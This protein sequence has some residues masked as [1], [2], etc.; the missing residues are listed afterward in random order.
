M[1]YWETPF[2]FILIEQGTLEL[3]EIFISDEGAEVEVTSL[4][5]LN[6]ELVPEEAEDWGE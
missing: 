5:P 2:G 1:R 4:F 6:F 3:G